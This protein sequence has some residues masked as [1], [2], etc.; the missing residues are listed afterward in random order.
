MAL[1]DEHD[2]EVDPAQVRGALRALRELQEGV[3]PGPSAPQAAPIEPARRPRQGGPL[4]ILALLGAFAC[5][6]VPAALFS[7]G[8]G[9]SMSR[10]VPSFRPSVGGPLPTPFGPVGPEQESMRRSNLLAITTTTVMTT[11]GV[12]A[13]QDATFMPSDTISVQ[14]STNTMAEITMECRVWIPSSCAPIL[15]FPSSL[16]V[17]HVLRQQKTP[18]MDQYLRIGP[19]GIMIALVPVILDTAFPTTMPKNQWCHVAVVRKGAAVKAFVNGQQVGSATCSSGPVGTTATPD[20]RIGAPVHNA[21]GYPDGGFTGRIDWLRV[22]SVAR[23]TANFTVPTEDSLIPADASTELL[24][25]FN[26]AP[27]ASQVRD[28]SPHHFASVVGDPS[29]FPSGAATAP[30]F[31][32][33]AV[34]PSDLDGNGEVDVSDISLLMLEFGPCP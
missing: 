26:E 9:A 11:A 4:T 33:P 2:L 3:D 28:D 32:G 5:L 25:R 34:C 7:G 10:S 14:G 19:D 8:R 21:V 15:P 17:G 1:R 6:T 16:N 22:S 31:P 29:R 24:L 27:G 23:Y 30:R 13:A 20:V 12:A 18:F